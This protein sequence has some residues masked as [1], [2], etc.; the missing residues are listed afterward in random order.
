MRARGSL[1]AAK[2]WGVAIVVFALL[3]FA[4]NRFPGPV[5]EASSFEIPEMES[6]CRTQLADAIYPTKS[7]APD[8]EELERARGHLVAGNRLFDDRALSSRRLFDAVLE[9]RDAVEM[10]EVWQERPAEYY[11]ALEHILAGESELCDR[12]HDARRAIELATAGDRADTVLYFSTWIIESIPDPSDPR[13][14]WAKSA[15]IDAR[16]EID[17][18]DESTSVYGG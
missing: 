14:R 4:R 12:Y 3:V 10:L 1:S 17:A 8:A 16:K 13:Y 5:G 11:D 6:D 7:G 18:R 15:Q 9:W 2:L